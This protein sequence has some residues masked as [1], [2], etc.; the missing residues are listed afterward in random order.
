MKRTLIALA[1]SL[2]LAVNS[3]TAATT[4]FQTSFEGIDL[5]DGQTS[6]TVPESVEN[7]NGST[8]NPVSGAG[9]PAAVDGNN[10][11][12]ISGAQ[13]ALGFSMETVIEANTSYV[14]S[15][16][17]GADSILSYPQVH[18]VQLVTGENDLVGEL[19]IESYFN[20]EPSAGSF[21]QYTFTVNIG[22]ENEYL[23]EDLYLR[24][25]TNYHTMSTGTVYY[26]DITVTAAAVPEPATYAALAGVA[27]LG[28]AYIRRRRK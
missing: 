26:D 28:L 14:V 18:H 3:M 15:L 2:L 21:N 4:L 19:V 24:L 16:S 12:M 17:V 25:A 6:S 11:A 7:I 9:M 27:T 8:V 23:G 10:I 5:D 1:S 22:E 20:N 13:G